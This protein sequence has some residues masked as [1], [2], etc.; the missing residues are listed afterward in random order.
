MH[1]SQLT[2]IC[3]KE[4]LLRHLSKANHFANKE[5]HAMMQPTRLDARKVCMRRYLLPR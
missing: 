1:S 2:H 4:V 5:I 3:N